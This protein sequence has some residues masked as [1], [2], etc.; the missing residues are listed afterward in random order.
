MNGI[1]YTPEHLASALIAKGNL[2][3][4]NKHIKIF[5]PAF[6]DGI[7]LNEASRY[8]KS[9][10]FFVRKYGCDLNPGSGIQNYI[11]KSKNL[12][13]CDFFSFEPVQKYDLCFLNPPYVKNN[14][15]N[16]TTKELIK[17]NSS[18]SIVGNKADLWAYMLLKSISHLRPGGSMAAILPW[19]FLQADYAVPLRKILVTYF[20]NI[21]FI[22]F[23]E[24]FFQQAEER[25]LFLYLENYGFNCEEIKAA[26]SYT[27][28]NESLLYSTYAP[29]DWIDS[30]I[31][32]GESQKK[33]YAIEQELIDNHGFTTVGSISDVRIGIVTGA[34]NF[35]IRTKQEW[36]DIRINRT[37][38]EPII[39]KSQDLF[40]STI[41]NYKK[42]ILLPQDNPQNYNQLIHDGINKN[43]HMRS[44]CTNRK[45]WYKLDL[46]EIPDAFFPYRVKEHPCFV[47]NSHRITCTNSVHRI[48][49]RYRITID[50]AKWLTICSLCIFSQ[51]SFLIKCKTYGR[52]MVK[53]EPSALKTCILPPIPDV[54]ITTLYDEI[55]NS[56]KAN[57]K[58]EAV[59]KATDV[60]VKQLHLPMD[61][62]NRCWKLYDEIAF[63][64]DR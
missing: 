22:A 62:V 37:Y 30:K 24:P 35:F 23:N 17:K 3:P 11:A 45:P 20:K 27:Y 16:S 55:L 49:F 64:R 33:Y 6:G 34:N 39:T 8:Y 60:I 4:R 15:I 31:L 61:L 53:L 50:Q 18:L 5:D 44:H 41:N 10:G 59:I 52:G 38:L 12:Q 43:I 63:S 7:L 51:L 48:Y 9:N 46:K 57:K 56:M 32:V 19:S 26:Y 40:E 28:T 2:I 47:Y 58:R 13:H 54:K 1:Y 29:T 25:I 42:V 36:D 14:L 21:R